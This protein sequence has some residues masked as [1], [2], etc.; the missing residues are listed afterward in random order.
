MTGPDPSAP[1]PGAP[2]GGGETTADRDDPPTDPTPGT[3]PAVDALFT[4]SSPLRQDGDAHGVEPPSAPRTPEVRRRSGLRSLLRELPVLILIAFV[5]AFLLRTFVV[6]VFYIP[7]SSMEPTLQVD[8]RILVEKVTY[9]VR[10]L[11]R[12]EIVVFEG[13]HIDPPEAGAVETVLRGLGQLIG[14][15]PANARDFV[16][17]I[18]GLPGD[19]IHIDDEGVVT[20]N[21]EVLDEPY[22]GQRDPRTCGPLTVPEGQ[23]FFLGDNRANSSDSRASLGYIPVDDVVGRA[24]ITIWPPER[25]HALDRP[26]YA[27]IPDPPPTAPPLDASDRNDICSPG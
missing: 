19:E 4:A 11:R 2:G 6:Q 14:V 10:D 27:G 12:G 16:K 13:D 9:R 22:L 20:V 24:F 15:T 1:P 25:F 21:G 17:R 5:L 18:I 26:T 8:D 23:L 7:S 3:D